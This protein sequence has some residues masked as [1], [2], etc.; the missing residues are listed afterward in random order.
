VMNLKRVAILSCFNLRSSSSLITS[1]DPSFSFMTKIN[2]IDNERRRRSPRLLSQQNAKSITSSTYE[3]NSNNNNKTNNDNDNLINK[4][5][6]RKSKVAPKKKGSSTKGNKRSKPEDKNINRDKFLPRQREE[7][8]KVLYSNLQVIGVDEAGRGPLAG[9]V[10]AA[11]AIIPT[12][13]VG[14]TDSKKITKEEDRELL[15]KKI[16]SSPYAR[17]SVAIVDAKRIDEINI[18]QATLQAMSMA[19]SSLIRRSQYNGKI[20]KD[21]TSKVDGCYVVCSSNDSSGEPILESNKNQDENANEEYFALIDG[22]K[23]PKDLPCRSEAMV[24]GDSREF[25]IAAASI[26]AK[27][28]RDRLM[29]EYDIEYPEYELSRHKGYPTAVHMAKVRLLGATTIHRRTFAPLK[30]M[31]FDDNGKI[32]E[33]NN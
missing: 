27:V 7:E 33:D 18:L 23:I 32:I 21:A 9:P 8:L 28:T 12:N 22:N 15:Y 3:E 29:H 30:H 24:K 2:T 26:L 14:V 19:A 1:S 5:R 20:A 11:A 17:W 16:V 13:I 31:I 6:K 10:V 25:S 4:T